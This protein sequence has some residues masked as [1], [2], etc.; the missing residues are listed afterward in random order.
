[1]QILRESR[2]W[3]QK[4]LADAAGIAQ[5]SLANFEGGRTVGGLALTISKLARALG[6]SAEWL[7]T[8]AGDPA[9]HLEADTDELEAL[10]IYRAL[11]ESDRVGWMAAGRAMI[12]SRGPRP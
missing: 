6:V 9:R 5:P 1:M 8:G 2:N 4:R 12:A 10:E 3:S 7:R 11:S